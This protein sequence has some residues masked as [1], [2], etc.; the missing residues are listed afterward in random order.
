MFHTNMAFKTDFYLFEKLFS[1]GNSFPSPQN[2]GHFSVDRNGQTSL[3][4]NQMRFL[5]PPSTQRIHF[6]LNL[7][8]TEITD[9]P[10]S[11][12]GNIN[13]IA[14]WIKEDN[15]RNLAEAEFRGAFVCRRHM[16]RTLISTPY[17]NNAGW[18]MA[19]IVHESNF[20]MCEVDFHNQLAPNA[21]RNIWL[22]S[23]FWGLKIEQYLTSDKSDTNPNPSQPR[24]L[25]EEFNV[26]N[27]LKTDRHLIV[28]NCEM[29]AF[30]NKDDT[31]V[32]IK[33]STRPTDERTT[34][35]Y[36][37][38]KLQ[39]WWAQSHL[40]GVSGVL[41]GF[42]DDKGIVTSLEFIPTASL[43]KDRRMWTENGCY[44]FLNEF[45]TWMKSVIGDRVDF[46]SDNTVHVFEY[47]PGLKKIDYIKYTDGKYKFLPD[48]F[49]QR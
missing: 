7:G 6:D 41:V 26:V 29:D 20:Y 33:T 14:N 19:V 9:E 10:E 43:P 23:C 49:L 45:L 44:H 27:K 3:D 47:L 11:K 46:C 25:L 32:E 24:N 42:R 2:I 31:F 5:K 39:K 37:R 15:G 34:N 30:N 36:K 48:W 35:N 12:K 4:K 38:F 22:K 40:G 18:K 17:E 1:S 21:D 8:F 13:Y 16:L 28:Y